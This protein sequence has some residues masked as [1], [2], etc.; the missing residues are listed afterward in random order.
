M[1]ETT[2]ILMLMWIAHE[3]NKVTVIL[4]VAILTLSAGMYNIFTLQLSAHAS[5]NESWHMNDTI[6]LLL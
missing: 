6:V 2:N 3:C 1:K 5:M 4:N